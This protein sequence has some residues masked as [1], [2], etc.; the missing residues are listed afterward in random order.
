MLLLKISL[1][2]RFSK[3]PSSSTYSLDTIVLLVASSQLEPPIGLQ[4]HLG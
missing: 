1:E 2:A 3:Y 4:W